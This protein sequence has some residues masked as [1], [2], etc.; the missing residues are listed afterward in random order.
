[1]ASPEEL[2]KQVA[3]LL[4]KVKALEAENAKLRQQSG[5]RRY[6]NVKPSNQTDE[7]ME[8]QEQAT[9]NRKEKKPPPF[10]ISGVKS[11]SVLNSMIKSQGIVINEM[12]AIANGDIKMQPLSAD[13][14]RK[15]RKLLDNTTCLNENDK[16]ELGSVRYHTYQLWDDKPYTVYIRYLHHSTDVSDITN[17]LNT[18][19]FEVIMV[20]NVQIKKREGEKSTYVK[21][22]LFKVDLKPNA[23][24]KNIFSLNTLLHYKIAVELPKKSTNV[25]QCKRCQVIGHTQNFCNKTPR[26]VKCGENHWFKLCKKPK[27]TPAKCANCQGDH[28]ANYRG[29]PAFKSKATE[30][31]KTSAVE[32]IKQRPTPKV[33]NAGNST[34]TYAEV[35]VA[36][37]QTGETSAPHETSSSSKLD[38]I[39]STLKNIVRKQNDHDEAFSRLEKRV[40]YLEANSPSSPRARKQP[41][42]TK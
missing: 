10:F 19:G 34:R 40:S 2:A 12:K 18:L 26:C 22:P 39:L 41:K 9:P 4:S 38:E 25:A 16:K 6:L 31:V 42:T 35:I 7:N 32:R 8:T 15:L 14:Y 3:E 20:T 11:N 24:N 17:E 29:C 13:D 37:S 30:V 5:I 27:T 21:L 33:R 23:E 36:G 1:M 28:T